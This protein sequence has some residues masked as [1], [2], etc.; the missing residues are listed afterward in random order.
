MVIY[1][2][3]QPMNNELNQ[4]PT[5]STY[6][7][8]LLQRWPEQARNLLAG[9]GLG[10]SLPASSTHISAAQQLQIFRN[11]MALTGRSDWGLVFG[12]QLNITSHGP[13]GFAALS[14]PTLGEGLDVL[15]QF[16]RI[17]APYI[18]FSAS[19]QDN[20]LCFRVDTQRYALGE[21]E[22]PLIEVL[23]QIA[24]SYVNAV[25]GHS[26]SEVIL[27]FACPAPPHAGLY[28]SYF[29]GRCEF[30]ADTNAF[31]IPA[32]LRRLPCPLH[33]EKTY[34]AA[35]MRCREALNNLLHPKDIK[36]RAEHWLMTHFD[37]FTTLGDPISQPRLDDLAAALAMSPRTLI[38]RLD[39]HGT[40]FRSLCSVQKQQL[41]C[42]LLSDARYS[43]SDIAL[44]LGYSDAANFGRAFRQMTGIAPGQYRRT[45]R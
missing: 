44:L 17:R 18:G 19:L 40:S 45:K 15:V 36:T 39:E 7:R 34:R 12:Q 25:M 13:L 14:A 2:H 32:G 20:L 41:A 21:L 30:N 5:P 22:L 27:Q 11:V 38:R 35:L 6:T 4:L 43:V 8:L 31:V 3:T 33:D 37:Q 10:E 1:R 16:A 29:A 42:R 24:S 28:A 26:A 23:M 9:T